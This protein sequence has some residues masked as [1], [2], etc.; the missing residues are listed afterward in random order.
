M[1]GTTP[2]PSGYAA[3]Y[4]VEAA[5]PHCLG[6]DASAELLRG[7]S[8]TRFAVVGDSLAEGLGDPL[9]G[10]RFA[11]WADRVAEALRAVNSGLAYA[12][13]GVRGLT[14][15][16]VRA[17]QEDAAARFAP[18]LLCVV[19]GGNDLLLPGFSPAVLEKELDLLLSRLA[20][21]GTTVFTYAL[22]DVARAVP[23]LRGG[24]L[25]AGVAV[26][27][28]V[29]RA[30][31]ARHG[32]LVVEMHGHPASGDRDLYSADLVHFSARGH[33]VAAAATL[34][35]L[36][37]GVLAQPGACRPDSYGSA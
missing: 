25:D 19:C 22:S 29:T 1:T 28:D 35:A 17:G 14:A 7:A 5:D 30:V 4:P 8:W 37:A 18:D 13:L 10:Y 34:R 20:A 6:P 16:Q 24:P 27:N 21:E 26:L 15:A 2:D 31:A 32:A 3:A 11:S 9:P 33:A 23:E 12:N 36:A